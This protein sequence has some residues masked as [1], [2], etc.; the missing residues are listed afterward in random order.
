MRVTENKTPKSPHI[1]QSSVPHN[2][3][4]P[5]NLIKSSDIKTIVG[6]NKALVMFLK[7]NLAN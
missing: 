5:S 1:I 6:D 3:H 2:H 7:Q 4:G